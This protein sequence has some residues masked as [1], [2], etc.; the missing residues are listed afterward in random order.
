MTASGTPSAASVGVI[1]PAYNA[2]AWV[3]RA[4]ECVLSQNYP[5]LDI[6]VVDDGSTDDTIGVLRSFGSQIRWMTGPNRGATF[7]R[8]RGLNITSAEYVLFL[9]ADDYIEP[10]SIRAWVNDAETAD[11]VLGPFVYEQDGVRK[12]G[13][14]SRQPATARSVITEWLEGRFTPPCAVLWRKSFV[15]SIGRWK[16]SARRNQDGELVIRALILGA[17]VSVSE[18]GLGVYVQH[19]A[20]DRVSRRAG[21]DILLNELELFR[22]LAALAKG[23]GDDAL[24]REFGH[25]F[26]RIAYEAFAS[27]I[28]DVGEI[29]SD[30]AC[31]LGFNAHPGPLQHRLLASALGLSAKMRLTNF[32]RGR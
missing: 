29:A 22:D 16:L 31:K 25:A 9:D 2:K 27:R 11:L 23:K 19:E 18:A 4:I 7:A 10:G 1:I 30:E 26:Y 14:R 15:D 20:A 5:S 13:H 24:F 17:R 3:G 8:N 21:R 28:H 32:V 6:I 12:V